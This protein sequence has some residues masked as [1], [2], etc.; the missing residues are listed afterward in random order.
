[1]G[2][3]NPVPLGYTLFPLESDGQYAGYEAQSRI[4]PIQWCSGAYHAP[5]AEC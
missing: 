5:M 2:L 4:E 1:M 3:G